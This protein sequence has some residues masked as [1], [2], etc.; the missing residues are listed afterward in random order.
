MFVFRPEDGHV[1]MDDDADF[2]IGPG[3]L[4]GI[5]HREPRFLPPQGAGQRQREGQRGAGFAD[6]CDLCTICFGKNKQNP[7]TAAAFG[8]VPMQAG[9]TPKDAPRSS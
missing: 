4:H 3:A 5:G 7:A 6:V 1:E 8:S 9:R 2:G